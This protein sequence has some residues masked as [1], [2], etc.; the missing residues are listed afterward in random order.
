MS[1]RRCPGKLA[2][3]RREARFTT[4]LHRIVLNAAR[5]RLRRMAADRRRAEGWGEV[6]SL[7][8]A[9]AVDARAEQEWLQDAMSALPEQL[10]ETVALVLGEDLTHAEAGEVL[11]VTEGTISWRMSEVRKTLRAMATEE[12][13]AS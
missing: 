5:D 12:R 13:S 9:E 10:R 4:W 7:R 3:F 2:G 1:A 8:R 6:E 11:G